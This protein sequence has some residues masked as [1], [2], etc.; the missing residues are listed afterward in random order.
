MAALTSDELLL[1]IPYY[2]EAVAMN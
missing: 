2:F 1:T